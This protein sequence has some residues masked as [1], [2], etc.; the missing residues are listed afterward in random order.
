M[1]DLERALTESSKEGNSIQ[2]VSP[3][4]SLA[5][6]RDQMA[7]KVSILSPPRQ[8]SPFSGSADHVLL[9]AFVQR[10]DWVRWTL[11]PQRSVPGSEDLGD[12]GITGPTNFEFFGDPEPRSFSAPKHRLTK[13]CWGSAGVRMVGMGFEQPLTA[14]K[15]PLVLDGFVYSEPATATPGECRWELPDTAPPDLPWHC[16]MDEA[17]GIVVGAMCSGRVWIVDATALKGDLSSKLKA[18]S[19]GRL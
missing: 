15:G 13:I 17:A 7:Y 16:A 11:V 8:W 10:Q 18:A 14:K 2:S 19:C 6:P 9:G 1:V 3:T 12:S 5:Y 4:Q